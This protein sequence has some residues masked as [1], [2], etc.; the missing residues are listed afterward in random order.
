MSN[1]YIIGSSTLVKECIQILLEFNFEILGVITDDLDLSSWC[2]SVDLKTYCLSDSHILTKHKY[3][4]LFSIVNPFIIPENYLN[5]VNKLA[6]NYH[7]SLLPK[8]CRR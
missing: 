6:I 4:Y 8:K 7:D 2:S 1:C 3:D 5:F